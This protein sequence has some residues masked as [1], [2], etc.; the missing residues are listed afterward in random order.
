MHKVNLNLQN[1]EYSVANIFVSIF[2]KPFALGNKFIVF[3]LETIVY[4]FKEHETENHRL[5]LGS[6]K[7]AT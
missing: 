2:L 6:I 1:K 3:C 7:I 4:I 5:I